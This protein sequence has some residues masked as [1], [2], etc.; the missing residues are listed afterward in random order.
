MGHYILL[1]TKVVS[2][3]YGTDSHELEDYVL[4]IQLGYMRLMLV[5]IFV[6]ARKI[7]VRKEDLVI[8]VSLNFL[9]LDHV[10]AV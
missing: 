10:G 3:W 1:G 4:G 9:L 6:T 7:L 8:V 5:S 2:S